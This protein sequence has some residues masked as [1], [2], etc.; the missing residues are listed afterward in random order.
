MTAKTGYK[1][2]LQSVRTY[3]AVGLIAGALLVFGIG[4]WMAT[5]ELAGA[6]VA[7]GTVVVVSNVKKVQHPSGGVIGSIMV[8]EGQRVVSAPL[9][10]G[11][12]IP[13]RVQTSP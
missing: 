4:G 8:K 11:S 12:M 2:G 6:V 1:T 13:S 9:C 10:S 5:A 3:M 7:Q